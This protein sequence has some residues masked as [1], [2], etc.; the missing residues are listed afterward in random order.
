M[1]YP[2][3]GALKG[4]ITRSKPK[5]IKDDLVAIP[6]EPIEQHKD[7]TKC[8]DIMILDEIPIRTGIDRT[9]SYQYLVCLN[10]SSEDE[11]YKGID[12]HLEGTTKRFPS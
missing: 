2:D 7:L 5:P 10:S 11:P 6:T 4:K 12:K 3:I 9:I 1:L 8:M